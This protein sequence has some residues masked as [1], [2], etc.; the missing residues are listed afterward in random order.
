MSASFQV[1]RE[2]QDAHVFVGCGVLETPPGRTEKAA[3]PWA[4]DVLPLVV[5]ANTSSPVSNGSYV[6]LP[7][8]IAPL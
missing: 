6:A 1:S 7:I 3:P 2:I 4:G 8:P 5:L